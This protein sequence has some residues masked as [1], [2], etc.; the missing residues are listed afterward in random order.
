MAETASLGSDDL[1]TTTAARDTAGVI[2]PPP[3]VPLGFLLLGAV[4]RRLLPAPLLPGKYRYVVGGVLIGAAV[5]NVVWSGSTMH[6]ANTPISPMEPVQRIVSSGPFAF[7]RNPIYLGFNLVYLGIA[8]LTN[9]RWPVLLWPA[10][11]AT[12]QKG[13]I[14]REERYLDAKFGEEY[15]DYKARVRRWL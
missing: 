4:A 12:L 15:R 8:I 1:T 14:E 5:A 7:S 6:A 11:I 3:L 2:G 10:M 13:V 9:N